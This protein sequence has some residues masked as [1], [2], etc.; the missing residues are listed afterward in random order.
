MAP[1]L[2]MSQRQ[3]IHDMILSRSLKQVDIAA[4]AG[5]SVRSIR[6]IAS[7][8]RMF[9]ST[10]ALANG[11][12]RR[13]TVTPQMREALRQR[14]LEKPGMYQDEMIVFLFDE[15]RTLVTISS[16]KRALA[17]MRWTKKVARRIAKER[18]ADLRDYYFHNLLPFHS[19]QLV[20]VDESG[21]DQRI[22]FR[23]TGW[24]PQI[25][26]WKGKD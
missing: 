5:C 17:S 8:I 9:G 6:T 13:A 21:C 4:L 22:G 10:R 11:A 2:S 3:M 24:S 19:W 20:Y 15:F 18:N 14:L 1:N 7:N 16:I 23:R 25:V 12:G 26:G